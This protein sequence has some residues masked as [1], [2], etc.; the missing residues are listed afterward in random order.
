MPTS[1]PAVYCLC[2]GRDKPAADYAPGRTICS[3]CAM[4][5]VNTI[6]TLVRDTANREHSIAVHTKNG[7]KQ[8][9]IEAKLARYK[10]E[11]KRCTACHNRKPIEDYNQCAPQPDGLQPICRTC[12]KLWLAAIRSGGRTAWYIIRDALRAQSPEGK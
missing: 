1:E 7:R 12:H 9:R 10:L 6:V 2:C 4:L 3:L 5:D 8:A 11:G